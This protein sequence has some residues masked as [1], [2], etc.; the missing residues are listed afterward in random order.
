MLHALLRSAFRAPRSTLS[1]VFWLSSIASCSLW[2][3]LLVSGIARPGRSRE[4]RLRTPRCMRSANGFSMVRFLL[5][6]ACRRNIY[7][8]L[9]QEPHFRSFALWG[10]PRSRW[11]LAT[12]AA[13]KESAPVCPLYCQW[14]RG[15]V[16]E[17]GAEGLFARL[18]GAE[19]FLRGRLNQARQRTSRTSKALARPA[20]WQS[21]GMC[22]AVTR[23]TPLL[24]Q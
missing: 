12:W 9:R 13:P 5:P 15:G 3:A 7:Q 1:V 4:D 23:S 14:S 17:R 8:A 21:S 16:R 2:W 10:R 24:H 6:R 22:S 18:S 19:L 20:Q 11:S